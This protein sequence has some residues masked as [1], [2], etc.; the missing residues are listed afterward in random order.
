M[1]SAFNIRFDCVSIL[2]ALQS[3]MSENRNHK[4]DTDNSSNDQ[5]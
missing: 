1:S 2:I 3:V 5:F 4:G